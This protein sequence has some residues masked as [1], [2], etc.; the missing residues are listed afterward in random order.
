MIQLGSLVRDTISG[1]EGIAMARAD[2]LTACTTYAV[3]A[4]G[5]HEG[6]PIAWQWFDEPRLEV[7]EAAALK[8]PQ[9]G[10]PG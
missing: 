1:F 5:L 10:L 4:K 8:L 6:K 3:A 9:S 7:V 2:Y